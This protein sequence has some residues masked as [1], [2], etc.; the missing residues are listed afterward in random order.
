MTSRTAEPATPKRRGLLWRHHDFRWFWAGQSISV[1]GTQVTSIALPLVAAL[2][3]DTGAGGVSVVAT[4]SFLPNVLLPLFAG[5]WLETRRRR[6]IMIAADILRTAL[7]ALVPLAWAL[8]LLSLPLLAAVAFG[9]GAASVMFDIGSFAYIP[10]LVTE[11]ELP[12][13]NQAVQGSATAAQVAGPGV[14]GLLV[15]AAGPAAAVAIDS[16]SYLASAL[17]L[18][19]A[20][21]PE[22]PPEVDDTLPTGILEGLKRILVNPILRALTVHAAVY[23]LS[24][25]ILTVNLIVWLVK[26]RGLSAGGYGLA[27]SAGG[28]GAFFGTMIALRLA[29]RLGYGHA[30]VAS[31]ALST[32]APLLLATFPFSGYALGAAVAAVQLVSGAGLGSANVLSVTLR[33][34]VAPRGSLARTNGGYR[35]LIFGVIPFGSA[36][37]GV[38]GQL[39]SSRAGVAVGAIGLT[40]S[41][42][43][44]ARRH[45]RTLRDPKDARRVMAESSRHED[46]PAVAS[47]WR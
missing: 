40:L 32:G 27:L 8:D 30:F 44:M 45:V 9:V 19:K 34:V 39:A 5:H 42:I 46:P 47:P 4:A 14:A 28:I 37:G 41:A 12:A 6:R 36:L 24:A 21:K 23:N 25:Q 18:A 31:L 33:Q 7:L 2:T 38:I 35:L 17:G 20:R 16:A 26:E 15:Q 1:L 43:P 10:S 29:R 13:A 11:E 3:L 22:S